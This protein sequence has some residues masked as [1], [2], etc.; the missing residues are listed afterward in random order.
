MKRN[1]G[2]NEEKV[3]IERGRRGSKKIKAAKERA[4]ETKRDTERNDKGRKTKI[5]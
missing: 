5:K 4:R 1:G 2:T 3:E